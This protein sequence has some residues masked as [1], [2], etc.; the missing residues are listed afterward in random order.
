[1]SDDARAE[2]ECDHFVT[3]FA[4]RGESVGI[5]SYVAAFSAEQHVALEAVEEFDFHDNDTEIALECFG[6]CSTSEFVEFSDREEAADWAE[7]NGMVVEDAFWQRRVDGFSAPLA[8][9]PAPEPI[10]VWDRWVN[11]DECCHC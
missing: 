1:L 10:C 6:W 8:N 4:R 7:L 3:T 5:G 9:R 2:A 11:V